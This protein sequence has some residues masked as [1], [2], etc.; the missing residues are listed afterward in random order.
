[1][2]QLNYELKE[3]IKALIDS[4]ILFDFSTE[5][6]YECS[7]VAINVYP[8]EVITFSVLLNDGSLFDYI[9]PSFVKDIEFDNTNI[10]SL[11]DLV[12]NNNQSFTF[13]INE[14]NFIKKH[15]NTNLLHCYFK[16]SDIWLKVRKYF[17]SIDWFLDNDKRHFVLLENGQFAF[18][19]N[20]KIKIGS[21]EKQ[22]EKFKKIKLTYIIY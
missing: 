19:P 13:I 2:E 11:K 9:P 4:T 17:F 5:G 6:S 18:V 22:F 7:I 8:N 14:F 10:L 1:M 12:Y 16:E 20:H 3:P 15:Q 21:N